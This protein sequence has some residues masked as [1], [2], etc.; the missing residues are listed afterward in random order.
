[1]AFQVPIHISAGGAAPLPHGGSVPA[2]PWRR[3]ARRRRALAFGL[4]LPALGRGSVVVAAVRVV[5]SVALPQEVVESALDR[6]VGVGRVPRAEVEECI[7]VLSKWYADKGFVCSSVRI[8]RWP[9]FGDEVLVLVCSEP[10]LSGVRLVEVDN[11]GAAVEG[12]VVKTTVDTVCR[13]VGVRI[14]KPFSWKPAGFGAL[15][16]LGIFE[17]AKAE[18]NVLGGDQVELVFSV[19]EKAKGRIEPGA[20]MRSDGRIYGDI[21]VVDNNFM[22][23]AQRLRLEWQRRLDHGRS[24]GGIEFEDPRVGANLPISYKFRAYRDSNSGRALP[25]AAGIERAAG[26]ALSGGPVSISDAEGQQLHYER[27]R[28]GGMLQVAFRPGKKNLLLSAAP[29]VEWVHPIQGAS[30]A[31]ST[32]QGVLQLA[33]THITR[34]PVDLPRDGHLFRIEHSLGSRLNHA[35]D[36]FHRTI[37]G[38]SQYIGAGRAASVA[39][40]G[41]LGIGSANLPWHEQKSLGGP[42]TVRGYS[43]GE[44]GRAKT[45]AVGRVE[46]RVPLSQAAS[47]ESSGEGDAQGT[48]GDN[49]APSDSGRDS[50]FLAGVLGGVLEKLPHLVAVL[51]ADGAATDMRGTQTLGTSYGLGIRVG[52]IISVEWTRAAHG[53]LSRLH[54]GLVDRNL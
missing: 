29:M 51:Y 52:G 9:R 30:D 40:G 17:Y 26:E 45:Y 43:Y 16:A 4:P 31:S 18:V 19:R 21:S 47:Q 7:A 14:G 38:L 8:G 44:L 46:L 12:G 25:G 2:A 11:D 23:R 27:D 5:G 54:F 48:Q 1:M 10:M 22:G 41:S 36:A 50:A 28:D 39:M 42:A 35:T 32:V 49:A 15:L 37:I 34:L 53:R 13:V 3:A 24:A 6:V 20:G 33:A